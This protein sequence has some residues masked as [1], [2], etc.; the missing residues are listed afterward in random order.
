[1]TFPNGYKGVKKLF[2]AEIL[3][4]ISSVLLVAAGIAVLVAL[5]GA[6]TAEGGAASVGLIGTSVFSI[7]AGILVI[8][9]YIL[10]LVGLKQA[11]KD[12]D[13]FHMAFTIAI[14]T[15]NLAIISGILNAIFGANSVIDDIVQLIQRI[16]NIVVIFMVIMG[17]QDF[18]DQLHN[19]KMANRGNTVTWIIAIP[20]ILSAIAGIIPGF[21]GANGTTGTISGVML[22]ISGILG[23][24]GSIM[25][26]V[27]LGQAK[28][29]L[30]NN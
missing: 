10:K 20:Y 9:A 4:L 8:I 13:R 26:L 5:A 19:D 1:M 27:Y 24:I 18:A 12:S 3:A 2:T 15:L 14:C 22:L 7:I 11:G 16:A 28:K 21:F 6:L 25:Y 29:M 30:K 17:I 23:I